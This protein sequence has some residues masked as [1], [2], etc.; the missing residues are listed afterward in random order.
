[1]G[2]QGW[3][4]E[5]KAFPAEGILGQDTGLGWRDLGGVGEGSLGWGRGQS[6][7]APNTRPDSAPEKEKQVKVCKAKKRPAGKEVMTGQWTRGL[8]RGLRNT[9]RQTWVSSS[10]SLCSS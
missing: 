8:Q 2:F 9:Y 10:P 5:E 4:L 7:G 1:M 3:K 6:K